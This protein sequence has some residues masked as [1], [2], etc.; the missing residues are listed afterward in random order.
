MRNRILEVGLV[1][2]CT[3]LG[4]VVL[5]PSEAK[6][7]TT[8]QRQTQLMQ[9]VNAG[10]KAKELTVKEA[11]RLRK[12]LA[13]VAKLRTKLTAKSNGKLTEK[14]DLE[15]EAALNKISTDI[16]EIQLEKRVKK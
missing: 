6:D 4:A 12:A 11:N 3:L 16:H 14:D 2:C 7:W 10:Q 8:E 13:Q 15:L 9:D 1:A 5:S